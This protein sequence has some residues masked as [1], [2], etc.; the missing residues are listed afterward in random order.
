MWLKC[1]LLIS[2][3]LTPVSARE[4]PAPANDWREA[5][6]AVL[7]VMD[8]RA[9]RF[10]ARSRGLALIGLA[11][12]IG[13]AKT[14]GLVLAARP[15]LEQIVASGYGITVGDQRSPPKQMSQV[16]AAKLLG[17]TPPRIS[18]LMRDGLS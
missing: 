16:Q 14:E 10:E 8:D 5:G 1:R 4:K 12:A 13:L 17:V 2:G 18:D 7:I 15:L 9:G 6:D 3:H 11:A